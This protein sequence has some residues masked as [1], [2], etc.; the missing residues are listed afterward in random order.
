MGEKHEVSM[1]RP[2]KKA[3]RN[4]V[5]FFMKTSIPRILAALDRGEL[6]WEN[7]KL[8]RVKEVN[9]NDTAKCG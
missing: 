9:G 8:V 5:E 7:G 3:Q 4:M 6:V 2:S 1:N